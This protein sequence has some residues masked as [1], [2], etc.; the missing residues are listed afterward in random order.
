MLGGGGVGV[1]KHGQ[2]I[3]PVTNQNKTV[4]GRAVVGGIGGIGVGGVS[5]ILFCL[6]IG[7]VIHFGVARDVVGA[8]IV[9]DQLVQQ[10]AGIFQMIAVFLFSGGKA[11]CAAVHNI[12]GRAGAGG[13][14]QQQRRN[15]NQDDQSLGCL[16]HVIS[17]SP[18][19][20]S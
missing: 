4:P 15:Q 17:T 9:I 10:R 12:R 5:G 3:V 18:F 6:V 20:M 7:I 8:G 11:V 16:H 14:G 2:K 1:V 19:K 13:Q